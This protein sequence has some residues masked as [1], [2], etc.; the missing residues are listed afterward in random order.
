M[1]AHARRIALLVL[2]AALCSLAATAPYA[3]AQA[4]ENGAV[5]FSAKRAGNRVIY[6][7]E[8]DGSRLRLIDTAGL[9]AYPA[10]SERGKRLAFT[11]YGPW[12]AQVWVT[13][14]DGTGLRRLTTGSS[15]T[16]PSW[17]PTGREVVFATGPSGRR[18]IY[19]IVAD[20]TGL[21]R[22]TASPLDDESPAWSA[23]DQVAF[24]RASAR[25]GDIYAMSAR[26]GTPRRVTRNRLDD[27]GPAWSPTGRT[28]AFSRGRAGQRDLYLVDAAGKRSRRLTAVPGDETDPA[29]SP[30]GTRVA[31]IHKLRGRTRLYVMKVKG[32]PIRTLPSR[33]LRVRR[34]TSAGSGA[35]APSWGPAAMDP[36]I[37]AAGDIACDPADPRFNGG[38]GIPRYCRQ[39]LSSDLLLRSDLARVLIPG[40]VQYEQGTLAQFMA[41]FHPTWGRARELISPVPG[42]HEYETPGAA[43][44]FD[45]F[46]GV[47]AA[48][49]PAGDRDKGYYSYQVGTWRVLALN[50]ECENIGGCGPDSPQVR[51]MRAELAA[52]PAVCTLAYWHGPRFTSGRFGDK[53]EAVR[54]L[55]DAAYAGGVDVVLSGHEHFYERFARQDGEGRHD[56]ARGV[57]QFTVGMGGK[58]PHGFSTVAPNSEFRDRLGDRRPGDDAGRGRLP[59]APGARSLE[60]GR[61]LR[62]RRLSLSQRAFRDQPQSGPIGDSEVAGVASLVRIRICALAGND[63]YLIRGVVLR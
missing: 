41:S 2:L 14:M 37:A 23:T 62:H 4:P 44:Y 12:G 13:Y 53:S 58:G 34:M 48:T 45:Y 19:R 63:G 6:T 49:G 25:R 55:F 61:G 8:R 56:P 59:M 1:P 28:I 3:A 21:K 32:R 46:N 39:K 50:S 33:S 35:G 9:A 27:R 38:V 17:A 18:D 31:F 26:G 47:G 7:R 20:G 11:K 15:D 52:N 30:D 51:W 57:R 54:P 24:V 16:M 36:V 60:R 22:L 40:D 29:F 10:V 5:A 42:N 43:G